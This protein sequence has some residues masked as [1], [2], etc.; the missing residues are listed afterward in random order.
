MQYTVVLHEEPGGQWRAIVPIPPDCTVDAPSREEVLKMIKERLLA[1]APRF[2]IV[3]IEA[4]AT[5]AQNGQPKSESQLW[6]GFGSHP[7]DPDWGDFFDE[8]DHQRQ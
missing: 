4:P 3:T 5:G 2:E 7:G 6:P 8:L 1:A